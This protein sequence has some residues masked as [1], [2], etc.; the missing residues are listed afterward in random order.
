ME[1]TLHVIEA[2]TQW[3][4]SRYESYHADEW[5]DDHRPVPTRAY[6]VSEI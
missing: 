6:Y 4:T 5:Y 2:W 3:Y 1:E